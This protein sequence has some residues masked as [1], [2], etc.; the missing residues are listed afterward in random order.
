MQSKTLESKY[1]LDFRK[2]EAEIL[3]QHLHSKHSIELIG[4]KRVG[5][6][7]FLRFFLTHPEVNNLY[8]RDAKAKLFITIDLGDLIER[9][10]FA[11]WRLFLKRLTD[12]IE[13]MENFDE[14]QKKRASTLFLNTIQ[15]GDH[16]L[17][18]DA[19]RELLR[20]ISDAGHTPAI[21][22]IKFD[23]LKESVTKEF[24]DNLQSLNDSIQNRLSYIF[25]S[26]RSLS[27]LAPFVFPEIELN[28]FTHK[29]YLKPTNKKDTLIV[30]Q[31]ILDDYK[32]NLDKQ[33]VDNLIEWSGGH[34]QFL[35][36]ST[37]IVHELMMNKEFE[38]ENL[39][40]KLKN[41]ERIQLQAEELINHLDDNEQEF[42]QNIVKNGGEIILDD[43]NYL[44]RSGL[45]T[46]KKNRF[47]IFSAYLYEYLKEKIEKSETNGETHLTKKEFLLYTLL[48][49]N[50]NEI[51]DREKIE[52]TVWP[53]YS[54]Y[55]VSD[56]SIDRL[57]SRLRK[58]LEGQESEFKIETIRTRGFRLVSK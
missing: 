33:I 34:I 1:P 55:G 51:I 19:V 4:M 6:G 28:A 31:T 56:W 11:F 16:F 24:F 42:L 58:K 45:V 2:E 39:F 18:L 41:D 36:L 43:N 3:G 46:K 22:F 23:R 17:T 7:N 5:I 50:K 52:E 26:F 8:V 48:D 21:F 13:N 29:M 20:M 38:E 44:I 57:V 54:N 37:V 32:M 12:T 35:E 9:E 40:E 25:T 15:T 30:F 10:L 49:E 14:E 47:S 27:R 53:E